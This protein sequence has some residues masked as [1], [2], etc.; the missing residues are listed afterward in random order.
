MSPL[1]KFPIPVRAIFF[2]PWADGVQ[3]AEDYLK[4]LP[5]RD[6]SE[7]VSNPGDASLLKMARLDCDWDGECLRAFSEMKHPNLKFLPARIAGPAG[8]LELAQENPSPA[9]NNWIILTGQRPSLVNSGIGRFLDIFVRKNHAL[10]WAFDEASRNMNCFTSVAPHLSV[11]IHDESPLAPE[12]LTYLSKKCRVLHHSWTA[13][14][15]PYSYPFQ[16]QVEE[17][18]VFLGSKLGLTPHRQEQVEAL[19]NHFKDRFEG[20]FNHS[21]PIQERGRFGRFKVHL[22]PEGR[23]FTTQGMRYTHTDRPFWSG[24]LGQVPVIEDSA[25]GSRLEDLYEQKLIYRYPHSNTKSMIEACEQ[26]LQVPNTER[27]R[28]YDYFNQ[29]ETIGTIIAQEIAAFYQTDAR[30]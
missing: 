16:E 10:Y 17:R 19:K 30:S 23:M 29:N 14:I 28:I 9:E 21:V 24:C 3:D 1:N 13:N 18:I 5:G 15:V 11:L 2:S 6:L 27:R 8:L 22:C 26:A 7:R 4:T 20:I 25:W 12:S